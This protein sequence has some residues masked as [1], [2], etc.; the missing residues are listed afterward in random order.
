[1]II[2]L[3]ELISIVQDD[4]LA[5]FIDFHPLFSGKKSTH[6]LIYS[7]HKAILKGYD[8]FIAYMRDYHAEINF[9]ELIFLDTP[10]LQE[11]L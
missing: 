9:N 3:C 2:H 5:Q 10:L 8:F 7:L 1:M 11:A 6:S 4:P